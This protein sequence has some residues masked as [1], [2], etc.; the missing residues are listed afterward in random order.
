MYYIC[1]CTLLH[2]GKTREVG[3]END[4]ELSEYM[5][6]EPEVFED[7]STY[8]RHLEVMSFVKIKD[9]TKSLFHLSRICIGGKS[10]VVLYGG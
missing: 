6:R 8:R 4:R 3:Q 9:T 10:M 5:H 1:C 7:L 2:L